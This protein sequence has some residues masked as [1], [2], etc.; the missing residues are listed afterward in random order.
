MHSVQN[1][2]RKHEYMTEI[3]GDRLVVIL[4]RFRLLCDPLY[5]TIEW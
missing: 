2:H 4:K 5:I 3:T 1:T